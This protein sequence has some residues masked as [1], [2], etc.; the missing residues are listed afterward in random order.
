MR[1]AGTEQLRLVGPDPDRH[2]KAIA[3]TKRRVMTA[4]ARGV[5]IAAKA[6][7]EEELH[8]EL[9]EPALDARELHAVT[10]VSREPKLA[11]QRS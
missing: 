1:A 7:A 3:A 8:P 11:D 4:H 9:R 6:L 2:G 10:R 5:P